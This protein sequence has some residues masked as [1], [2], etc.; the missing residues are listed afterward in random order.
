MNNELNLGFMIGSLSC[1][2]AC[3]WRSFLDFGFRDLRKVPITEFCRKC[4]RGKLPNVF[5]GSRMSTKLSTLMVGVTRK[6]YGFVW[7]LLLSRNL[8]STS[9][10]SSSLQPNSCVGLESSRPGF[11]YASFFRNSSAAWPRKGRVRS[12]MELK[13]RKR[14]QK[15]HIF[16]PNSTGAF[17]SDRWPI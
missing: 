15:L 10:S 14:P 4:S 9:T 7:R 2:L 3:A 8:F 16:G 5:T 17:V 13:W 11:T 1:S 6:G 12:L